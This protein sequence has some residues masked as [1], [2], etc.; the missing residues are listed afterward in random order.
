MSEP[1]L[2][3]MR[4]VYDQNQLEVVELIE[5]GR[6]KDGWRLFLNG[7]ELPFYTPEGGHPVLEIS[8]TAEGFDVLNIQLLVEP[9][10]E[11]RRFEL[12]EPLVQDGW[13]DPGLL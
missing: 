9:G 7:R 1:I 4:E 5:F 10:A 8:P 12:A 11:M 6:N 13:V 3:E 2:S